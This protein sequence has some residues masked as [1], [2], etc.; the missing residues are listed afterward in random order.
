MYCCIKNYYE[1]SGLKQHILP[2]NFYELGIWAPLTGSSDSEYF[3]RLCWSGLGSHLTLSWG[4][5]HFQAH[6][7]VGKIEFLAGY[8]TSLPCAPLHMADCSI[9]ATK[10]QSH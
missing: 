7:V 3:T 1:L 9:K 4:R 10:G 5:I 2:Q 6:V 8:W